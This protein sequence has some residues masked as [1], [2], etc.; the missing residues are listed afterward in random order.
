[1]RFQVR[2]NK[3]K[4][5]VLVPQEAT[6]VGQNRHPNSLEN[7]LLLPA[8]ETHTRS[9]G[10]HLPD[11][12]WTRGEWGGWGKSKLK[13]HKAL[14]LTCSHFFS[15]LSIHVVWLFPSVLIM[16]ILTVSDGFPHCFWGNRMFPFFSI[17][18]EETLFLR[19]IVS[20]GHSERMALGSPSLTIFTDTIL[21]IATYSNVLHSVVYKLHI[22]DHLYFSP[23]P[24]T[25]G[26]VILRKV[27]LLSNTLAKTKA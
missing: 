24:C 23:W 26:A 14:L 4:P 9:M 17:V 13:C 25:K 8:P 18:S 7:A 22:Q 6:H 15:W 10:C 2:W 16:L 19:N 12:C 27:K 11:C 20:E 3:D 5:F 1:M 21:F